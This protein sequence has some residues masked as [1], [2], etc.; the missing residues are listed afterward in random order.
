MVGGSLDFSR[1]HQA[2]VL[3]GAGGT[4]SLSPDPALCL[5]TGDDPLGRSLI[6]QPEIDSRLGFRFCL[7]MPSKMFQIP[8]TFNLGISENRGTPSHHPFSWEVPL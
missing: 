5:P 4:L 8:L 2:G 3:V 6:D 1:S 7:P